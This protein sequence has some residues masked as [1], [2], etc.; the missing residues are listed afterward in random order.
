M[1]SSV[2]RF[3]S[4][5]KVSSAS[6]MSIHGPN[7]CRRSGMRGCRGRRKRGVDLDCAGIHLAIRNRLSRGGSRHYDWPASSHHVPF[8]KP[9]PME[10]LA[11]EPWA[12]GDYCLTALP[13]PA[14]SHLS[15]LATAVYARA[16]RTDFEM[17]GFCLVDLG[18]DATSASLRQVM[19]GLKGALQRLHRAN[20]ARDLVWLSAGRFDQQVTTRFHRDGGPEE[21]L[22][23]LGYEP[24]KV[25]SDFSLAD[26]SRC[27]FDLGIT[28]AR[29]LEKHNPM[30]VAGEELL[31]PYTTHVACFSNAHYQVL[32]INNIVAEWH[33]DRRAWQGVL[34]TARIMNPSEAH[35]RV[36]N[37][38]MVA[39][40]EIGDPSPVTENDVEEF[41]TTQLVRQH[42]YTKPQ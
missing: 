34:H 36:V 16:C 2:H 29:F 15:E 28:P 4:R 33:D 41:A 12:P 38:T 25:R 13:G 22:L 17:P 23:I 5:R 11:F 6:G 18:P 30:F 32:V 26:Y 8:Q 19:I 20:A 21:C 31:R 40:V 24:T 9:N 10:A 37:S 35:Q 1:T 39:S 7:R 14:D 42:G 27:A 3:M